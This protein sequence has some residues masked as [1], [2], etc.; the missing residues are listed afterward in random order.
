MSNSEFRKLVEM[1]VLGFFTFIVDKGYL[2]RSEDENSCITHELLQ[3]Y[4]KEYLDKGE[5]CD[6]T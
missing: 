2:L 5:P 1:E 4:L 6:P 3:Q